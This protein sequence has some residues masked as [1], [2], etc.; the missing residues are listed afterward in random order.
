M[1]DKH[2]PADLPD[3]LS[4]E[5]AARWEKLARRLLIGATAVMG[6]LVL[7]IALALAMAPKDDSTLGVMKALVFRCH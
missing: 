7:L 1:S 5:E 3:G 2:Q 6:G 4:P